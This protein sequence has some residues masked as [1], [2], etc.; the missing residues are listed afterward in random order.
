MQNGKRQIGT[1]SH[2]MVRHC[3]PVSYYK[4]APFVFHEHS[5]WS[6]RIMPF[7]TLSWSW[8]LPKQKK[9]PNFP[10][11]FLRSIIRWHPQIKKTHALRKKKNHMFPYCF[12]FKMSILDVDSAAIHLRSHLGRFWKGYLL[13]IL[14][15]RRFKLLRHRVVHH[16]G[17]TSWLLRVS[18]LGCGVD[19]NIQRSETVFLE[20]KKHILAFFSKNVNISLKIIRWYRQNIWDTKNTPFH[21]SF[22]KNQY[23]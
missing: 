14:K 20:Q 11:N 9:H 7:H 3:L 2:S 17:W 6:T 18:S 12:F 21:I 19:M 16:L 10:L 5:A 15:E 13:S 1:F 22:P 8:T 23:K 4:Y